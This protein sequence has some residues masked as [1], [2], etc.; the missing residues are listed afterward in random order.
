MGTDLITDEQVAQYIAAQKKNK[1]DLKK[2]IRNLNYDEGSRTWSLGHIEAVEAHRKKG[3]AGADMITNL[4][5]EPFRD[6]FD[7]STGQWIRGNASR[8]NKDELSDLLLQAINKA[9]T[10][11][12]D[13]VKFLDPEVGNFWPRK[14]GVKDRKT[15][16]KQTG[17][18]EEYIEALKSKGVDEVLNKSDFG[19]QRLTI[20][21]G[22]P[23]LDK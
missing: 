17:L 10:I 12:E 16:L 7:E 22:F 21:S 4:E 15:W 19:K 11:D 1:A 20:R 3:K 8:S 14:I 5:L 13:I 18:Q 23:K 9:E 2:L 6:M